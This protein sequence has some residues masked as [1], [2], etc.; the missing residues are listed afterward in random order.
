MSYLDWVHWQAENFSSLN[1]GGWV[2]SMFAAGTRRTAGT[3]FLEIHDSFAWAQVVH[4]SC[5]AALPEC[6]QAALAAA[7]RCQLWWSSLRLAFMQLATGAL[8]ATS[9]LANVFGLRGPAAPGLDPAQQLPWDRILLTAGKDYIFYSS[10]W[11][12]SFLPRMVHWLLEMVERDGL[13]FS[14]WPACK[15]DAGPRV[16]MLKPE[17][18]K[19]N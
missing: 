6:Q 17:K 4:T 18:V 2:R 19:K 10:C 8:Y 5:T 3:G 1:F 13:V 9:L 12:R 16:L 15:C 14:P 11:I 7:L